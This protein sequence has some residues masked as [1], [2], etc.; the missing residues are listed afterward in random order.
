MHTMD[1]ATARQ[2]DI[3]GWYEIPR[4]PIS[5]VGIFDYL[6]KTIGGEDPDKIYRVL[7]PA[8][9]LGHPECI[10]SFKLTPWIDDHTFLG[11]ED[12]ARPAEEVG[13][14]GVIGERVE[15]DESDGTLYGNLKCF[16]S[17][18][19]RRVDS[20]KRDLSLG[21]RSEYDWT[22]GTYNGDHYD[23]I[24]RN[25]RGNHVASVDEGRMGKEVA[26]MDAAL[27]ITFDTKD[28]IPMPTNTKTKRVK[29]GNVTM[30]A[31]VVT[32][33]LAAVKR[34]SQPRKTGDEDEIAAA[35]QAIEAI[36]PLQDVLCALGAGETVEAE[37]IPDSTEGETDVTAPPPIGD[38]EDDEAKKKA[39][40]EAKRTADEEAEKKKTADEEAAK[41]K[42]KETGDAAVARAIQHIARRDALAK[43]GSAV[44]GSFD[45]SAMTA[46]QVAQYIGKKAGISLPTGDAAIS[47]VEG[48]LIG[49]EQAAKKNKTVVVGDSAHTVTSVDP[50][51]AA[52]N[53]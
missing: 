6:G 9:E 52:A 48:F 43:R 53:K 28:F 34:L 25:I 46:T 51:A 2:H 45:H 16:S 13:V 26:V 5:K 4:N 1:R 38:E 35:V 33:G 15:F 17:E 36:A 10:E 7:R 31:A 29:I 11:S 22:P 20:G 3:N 42:T 19:A 27:T 40:E 47:T 41:D 30:D 49:H 14:H 44:I 12:G 32:K 50:I 24:Q 39:E 23:A 18:H 8:E 37:V 21:Y